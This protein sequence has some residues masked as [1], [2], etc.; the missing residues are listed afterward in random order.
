[1]QGF[2]A[3]AIYGAMM[4]ENILASFLLNKSVTF[5]IIEPLNSTDNLIRHNTLFLL[6]YFEMTGT[7]ITYRPGS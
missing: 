5:F 7:L 6:F 3:T 1:M 2:A 4:N